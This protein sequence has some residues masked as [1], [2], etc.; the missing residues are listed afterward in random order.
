MFNPIDFSDPQVLYYIKTFGYPSLF[1]IMIVEGPIITI[2]GAFL[3]SLGFF[4]IWM[5]FLLSILGDIVGDIIL[6]ALGYFGGSLMLSRMEKLL[7]INFITMDK[8]RRLFTRHGQKTIFYVKSTTGLCW[9]TFI[10]AGTLKMEFQKFLRASF[11]GGIVW[12]GFLVI[13]GFFFGYAF[14]KINDYL[15]YAGIIIF[16]LAVFFVFFITFYKKSQ[17][18]KILENIPQKS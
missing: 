10:L 5:I 2:I 11:W 14:E 4:N 17:S 16:I 13:S 15:K 7:K 3:A 1:L 8:L 18:R 12:S 9:I 6:Y